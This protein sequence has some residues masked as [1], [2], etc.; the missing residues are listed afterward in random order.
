VDISGRVVDV[1]ESDE[2]DR[3]IDKMAK[4][5]MGQD[6]YPWRQPGE[7]RILF[8]IEPERIHEMG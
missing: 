5:Y 4:K 3:H 8:K 7:Q 1:D 6:T 2:A